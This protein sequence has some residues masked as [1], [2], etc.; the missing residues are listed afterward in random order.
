MNQSSLPVIGITLGDPNGVG[1]EI[2]LKA[3]MDKRVRNVCIPVIIGDL[4]LLRTI[5]D[6]INIDVVLE[7]R[8]SDIRSAMDSSINR[9]YVH[10]LA[11]FDRKKLNVG[12]ATADGGMA[13]YEYIEHAAKLAMDGKIDAIATSPISKEALD[14]ARLPST[15]HTEILAMLTQTLYYTMMLTVDQF[16]VAHVSTHVSLVEACRLVSKERVLKTIRIFVDGLKSLGV[17]QPRIGVAGLNP[18]AGEGGLFGRE[19]IESIIP[20]IQA[21]RDK[22]IDVSGPYPPDTIFVKMKG[23]DLDGV[24]AMYHDQGHIPTKLLGFEQNVDGTLKALR[25]TNVT[26]GL[27]IIRTSVDHGVAYDIAGENKA[28]YTSMVEAVEMAATLSRT[29]GK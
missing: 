6:N 2:V 4:T 25:G 1:P 11:N 22:G 21:A 9:L 3:A 16:R 17:T 27:P 12:Q 20:A 23:G 10:D 14:L 24:V 26:L 28:D 5:A 15:G 29:G 19:E 8:D 7:K 18:H 13:S